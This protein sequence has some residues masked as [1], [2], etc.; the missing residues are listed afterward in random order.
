MIQKRYKG[1]FTLFY[2]PVTDTG[3]VMVSGRT[4]AEWRETCWY[5]FDGAFIY[6]QKWA[7]EAVYH[8]RALIGHATDDF[9]KIHRFKTLYDLNWWDRAIKHG[10]EK[11]A[12]ADC[13]LCR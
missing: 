7:T 1:L 5:T 8:L 12:K 6:C 3:S 9:S 2:C 13:A 11:C 4:V 10:P